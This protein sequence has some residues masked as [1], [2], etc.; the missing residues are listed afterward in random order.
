M[1][2]VNPSE[3]DAQAWIKQTLDAAPGVDGEV[4]ADVIP[5]EAVM[6]AIRMTCQSRNDVRTNSQHIAVSTFRFLVVATHFEHE[7]ANLVPV[8]KAI[9][10]ALHG[11]SGSYGDLQV[12]ACTRIQTYGSTSSEQG[13]LYRIGGAIYEIV[14]AATD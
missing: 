9:D 4:Y 10:A 2:A 1:S 8:V 14:A 5:T 11:A 3:Y 7:L 6:P 13:S 12:L